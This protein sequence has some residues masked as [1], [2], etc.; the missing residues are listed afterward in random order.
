MTSEGL[1]ALSDFQCLVTVSLAVR[2]I[3][4]VI[5]HSGLGIVL[6]PRLGIANAGSGFSIVTNTLR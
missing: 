1:G 4:I 5:T 2:S 3:C 6:I